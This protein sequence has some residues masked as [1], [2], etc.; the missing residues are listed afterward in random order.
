MYAFAT[1]LLINENKLNV[2]P[3]DP[4]VKIIAFA[5]ETAILPCHI[6]PSDDLPTVEWSKENISPNITFLYRGCETFAEKNPLF[7]DRTNIQLDKVKDGDLSQIIH[8]VRLSDAGVYRC[9]GQHLES[10]FFPVAVSKPKLT[11]VPADDGVMLQCTAECWFPEPQVQFLDDRGSEIEAKESQRV[12]D[13]TGCFTITRTVTN[14]RHHTKFETKSF[15]FT[16]KTPH[17][18][19]HPSQIL[20]QNILFFTVNPPPPKHNHGASCRRSLSGQ[21]ASSTSSW[22][23]QRWKY[24]LECLMKP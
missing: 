10:F 15:I 5:N 21:R 16:V 9:H 1:L 13:P 18:P 17:P 2:A 12:E 20:R 11:F 24:R 22:S 4:I 3:A 23:K 7:R 14:I 6:D 8:D 19:H